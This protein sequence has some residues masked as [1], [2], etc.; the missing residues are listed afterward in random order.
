MKT[1]LGIMGAVL[2]AA[3]ALG[4][5]VPAAASKLSPGDLAAAFCSGRV[6]GNMDAVM[7]LLTPELAA[8]VEAAGGPE[9]VAWQSNPDRPDSCMTVGTRGWVEAPESV[10]S[11]MFMTAGHRNFSDTL[12]LNFVDGELRIDDI[13]FADGTTLRAT[14]AK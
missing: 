5:A 8:L 11:Y 14:L 10:L 2:A 13:K 1:T 9:A 12:V 3:L 6:S 7:P 4:S